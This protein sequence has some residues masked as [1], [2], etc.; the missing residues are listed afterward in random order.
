MA[1]RFKTHGGRYGARV[2]LIDTQGDFITFARCGAS[3]SNPTLCDE[4]LTYPKCIALNG[5]P[6]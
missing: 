5:G 3:S 1:T 6:E 4:P 2:H